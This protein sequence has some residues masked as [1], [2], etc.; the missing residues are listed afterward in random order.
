MEVTLLGSRLESAAKLLT[1]DVSDIN[2]L[3]VAAEVKG[4]CGVETGVC[5]EFVE[6]GGGRTWAR[7]F[8]CTA[9]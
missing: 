9:C 1:A 4:N 3:I 2:E 5:K 6:A 7:L 8:T